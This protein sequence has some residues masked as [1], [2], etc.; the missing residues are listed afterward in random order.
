MNPGRLAAELRLTAFVVGERSPRQLRLTAP[1]ASRLTLPLHATGTGLGRSRRFGLMLESL[2]GVGI[3]VER[4][5]YFRY[6]TAIPGRTIGIDGGHT[7]L[8]ASQPGPTWLFAEG[9]TGAGFDAYLTVLNPA[10][11]P[12][13]V[14]LQ[15]QLSQGGPLAR[16]LLLGPQSQQTVALHES[17]QVG[18]DQAVALHVSSRHV[19]IVAERTLYFDYRPGP[20]STPTPV[21]RRSRLPPTPTPITIDDGHSTIGYRP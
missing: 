7:V 16:S 14:E 13:L 18:R 9:Y 10:S 12:T 6:R 20:P 8:G 5:T 1:A 19:P 15:Y 2:N 21:A 11:E 3:V 4:P 17:S